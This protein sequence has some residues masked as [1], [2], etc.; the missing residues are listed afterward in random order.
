MRNTVLAPV[1]SLIVFCASVLYS[2]P[3]ADSAVSFGLSSG[4]TITYRVELSSDRR[5]S[6]GGNLDQCEHWRVQA[7]ITLRC[8]RELSGNRIEGSGSIEL[9]QCSVFDAEGTEAFTFDRSNYVPV[10]GKEGM[11]AAVMFRAEPMPFQFRVD[12]KGRVLAL[13]GADRA[14][15]ALVAAVPARDTTGRDAARCL[16]RLAC[17]AGL[18]DLLQLQF[19]PLALDWKAGGDAVVSPES[20]LIA[21][22]WKEFPFTYRQTCTETREGVE[23]VVVPA[24]LTTAPDEDHQKLRALEAGDTL[25][26]N[27]ELFYD[28]ARQLPQSFEAAF[29]FTRVRAVETGVSSVETGEIR[30]RCDLLP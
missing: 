5:V 24:R 1:A 30:L 2:A 16:R 29:E 28:T 11:A 22:P 25:A 18:R 7:D 21:L 4:Q 20:D 17:T 10:R 3:A 19:A 6:M 23:G 9:R 27:A 14:A 12:R 26:G 8:D 13:R 15:E